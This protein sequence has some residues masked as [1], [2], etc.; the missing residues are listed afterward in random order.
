DAA[1]EAG[2]GKWAIG[3]DSDQ[4][5]SATP[6]QQAHILTSMIKRVDIAVQT[7]IEAFAAGETTGRV[8]VHDLKGDGIGYSTSG[9]YI[10]DIAT[11]LDELKQ[12]I[13]DGTITVP[14]APA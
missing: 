12:Q 10:D 5:E 2:E 14:T 9:G 7:T 13:I 8:V 11:Q 4:Y 1:V 3:V 6:E